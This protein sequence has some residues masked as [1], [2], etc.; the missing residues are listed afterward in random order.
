MEPGSLEALSESNDALFLLPSH[1]PRC[2]GSVVTK[3]PWL[4]LRVGTE[5]LHT[6]VR[7]IHSSPGW[8]LPVAPRCTGV[9]SSI[10]LN[11]DKRDHP[12][13]CDFR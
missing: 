8:R 3:H 6:A 7:C 4:S 13:L 2:G 9:R 5:H 11:V 10:L 12:E 1:C